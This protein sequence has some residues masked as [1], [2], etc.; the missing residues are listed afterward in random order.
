[1]GV[2]IVLLKF[3]LKIWQK[4]GSFRGWLLF[5]HLTHDTTSLLQ[6]ISNFDLDSDSIINFAG[7]CA[8]HFDL[9]VWSLPH[10]NLHK[11]CISSSQAAFRDPLLVNQEQ[12]VYQYT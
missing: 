9:I 8:R 10:S 3:S 6:S 1:M 12:Y 2:I 5:D 4:W 11:G 7:I